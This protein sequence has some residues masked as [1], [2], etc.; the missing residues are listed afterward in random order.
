M[1][2]IFAEVINRLEALHTDYRTCL[3]GLGS[4]ELDWSSGARR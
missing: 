1:H 3:A 2:A 4:E